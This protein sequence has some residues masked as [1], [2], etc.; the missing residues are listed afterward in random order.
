VGASSGAALPPVHADP[1]LLSHV[2]LDQ[3]AN[4]ADGVV[5][6]PDHRPGVHGLTARH[7]RGRIP[8]TEACLHRFFLRLESVFGDSRGW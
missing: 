6:R 4:A 7:P 3:L 2:L 5:R 1:D 8:E